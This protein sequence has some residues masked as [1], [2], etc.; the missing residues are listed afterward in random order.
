VGAVDALGFDVWIIK[1]KSSPF[2]HVWVVGDNGDGTYWS[3]DLM[4]T[5]QNLI[6]RL[7]CPAK[8]NFRPLWLTFDPR[9]LDTDQYEV[10][11][12]VVTDAAIDQEVRAEAQA[13]SER[14]DAGRYDA[15]GRNCRTY[16][17]E[18]CDGAAY[19]K[20]RELLLRRGRGPG[21]SE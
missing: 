19:A 5:S 17:N 1:D 12:H 21:A 10:L 15:I 4:P 9:S 13:A 2:G 8:I 6:R 20:L 11:R 7:N 16:A 14:D 18:I 3:S